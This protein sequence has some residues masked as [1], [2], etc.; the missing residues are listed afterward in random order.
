LQTL[1]YRTASMEHGSSPD[2]YSGFL[3]VDMRSG[4][5]RAARVRIEHSD[6]LPFHVTGVVAELNVTG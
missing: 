6:P 3:E 1:Y 5:D 2:L 4:W